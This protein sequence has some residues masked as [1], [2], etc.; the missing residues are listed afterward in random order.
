M[1]FIS[2]NKSKNTSQRY[3]LRGIVIAGLNKEKGL[4]DFCGLR[5]PSFLTKAKDLYTDM[6]ACCEFFAVP[7]VLTKGNIGFDTEEREPLEH[8]FENFL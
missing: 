3:L 8:I 6:T 7:D 2:R 1:I 5:F 4:S